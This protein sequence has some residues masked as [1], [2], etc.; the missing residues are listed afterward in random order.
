MIS[1]IN[2]AVQCNDVDKIKAYLDIIL[3]NAVL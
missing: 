2:S 1:F 3:N